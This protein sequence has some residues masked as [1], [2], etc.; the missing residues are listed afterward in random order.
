MSFSFIDKPLTPTGHDQHTS[1]DAAA[2]KLDRT[3]IGEDSRYVLLQAE[4]NGVR[5]RDDGVLPTASVGMLI[6]AGQDFWYTGNI[7]NLRVIGV[8]GT[9]ILNVAGYKP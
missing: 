3:N 1:F 2:E 9:S 6:P 5:W 8:D 7:D 4:T